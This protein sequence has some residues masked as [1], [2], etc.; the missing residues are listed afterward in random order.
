MFQRAKTVNGTRGAR[1]KLIALAVAAPLLLLATA[2]G[3]DY[4][5]LTQIEAGAHSALEAAA[6]GAAIAY[7]DGVARSEAEAQEVARQIFRSR[8]PSAATED[9]EALRIVVTER[10]TLARYDGWL[11][12]PLRALLRHGAVRV[13]L[14]AIAE[15]PLKGRFAGFAAARNRL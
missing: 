13:N 12:T 1:R 3:I 15:A 7:G 8:A 11:A 9:P 6:R 2:A 4:A 5:H 14:T 10:S